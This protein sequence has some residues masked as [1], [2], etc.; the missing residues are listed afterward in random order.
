[1]TKAILLPSNFEFLKLLKNNNNRDWFNAHKDH[2][3]KEL[4]VLE[5]FAEALLSEMNKHDVIETPNGKKSLHR[6]YRD[7]RFSKDKTPYN[8]HWGGGLKRASKLRRGSYYFHLS[9]GNSFIAGGFWG[10]EASDLKRIREEFAHDGKSFRKILKSKSF[11]LHFEILKGEKIKTTPKG[12]NA[13]DPAIDLLRHKQFLLIKKFTD[14]EVMAQD[15]LKKISEVYKAM[16]PF[17]DYMSEV[18][19][20]NV[21]GESF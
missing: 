6:I 11:I 8:N 12:F 5:K 19:S 4:E 7:I 17:L 3:L 15:F 16:R 10:P 1:M 13:D 14:Q 20:T 2:Y 18:L 9:P 21:N